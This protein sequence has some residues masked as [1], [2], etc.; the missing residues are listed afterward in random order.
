MSLPKLVALKTENRTK[1]TSQQ[2]EI[3]KTIFETKME[4]QMV[5]RTNSTTCF[6]KKSGLVSIQF[7]GVTCL[8]A[9]CHCM[10]YLVSLLLLL[11][12]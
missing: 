4:Q 3:L 7:F 6:N 9:C 5:L 10:Y 2:L 12:F 1:F 11:L 8:L